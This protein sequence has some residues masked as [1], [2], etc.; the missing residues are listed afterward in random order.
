M[1]PV[2]SGVL[3]VLRRTRVAIPV[4]LAVPVPLA[5][6]LV[7][8]ARPVYPEDACYYGAPRA[9]ELATEEYLGLMT[10]LAMFALAVIAWVA[11]PM[12]DRWRFLAPAVTLWAVASLFAADAA[13]AVVVFGGT[14]VVFGLILAIPF[15][16]IMVLGGREYS[17]PRAV[18]WFEFLFLVPVLLGV[19][20]LL[21]QPGCY[22]GDPVA[23]ISQ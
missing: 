19:A 13:R 22:T 14:M 15:V 4:L 2:T 16:V 12:R 8:K 9:A 1:P 3:S 21:A 6:A 11:L 10:S 20:G 17:W 5:V 7:L 23:P 18:G